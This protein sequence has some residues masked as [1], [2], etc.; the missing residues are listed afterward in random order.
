MPKTYRTVVRL[1]ARSDTLRRRRHGRRRS[2][3]RASPTEAEVRAAVAAQVGT[4][5]QKPPEFSALEGRGPAR[6]RP[7][8]RRA[9]PS[10]WPRGRSRSTGST[11]LGY[12]WPRLELEVECGGGTY[13][14]S[15]ARDVGEALG[16]GGL[17]EVLVRTRIGP[18][19]L[20]DAV[21]PATLSAATI[22]GLLRP[23][24]EAVAELPAVRSRP[25]QVADVAQGRPRVASWPARSPAGEV[26]LLGPDGA[27]VAVAEADPDAGRGLAPRGCSAS[28][29]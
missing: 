22:P 23:A 19:T 9:R 20:A 16:C 10:T 17:V 13:I 7:R 1:G 15:I 24:A 26:A 27:L 18:F 12:D 6:L 11:S 28:A 8:P 3:R 25:E 2:R 21:D 29:G 4:I 5:L 14:R